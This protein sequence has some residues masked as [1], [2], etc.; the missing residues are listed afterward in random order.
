MLMLET[1]CFSLKKNNKN[2]RRSKLGIFLG[3]TYFLIV[4]NLRPRHCIVAKML[5]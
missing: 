4:Q 2:D 1:I 3:L 5:P